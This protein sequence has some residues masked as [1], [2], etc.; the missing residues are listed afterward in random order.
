MP[1]IQTILLIDDSPQDREMYLRYLLKDKRY[2]YKI[3]ETES[4]EEGLQLC[5]E[6]MPDV[7]LL[8]YRLPDFDGLEVLEELKERT[9]K[10]EFP[11]V[12]LTGQGNEAIAV[13]A[14]KNGARDYLVKGQLTGE[15]LRNI[16]HRVIDRSRLMRQLQQSQERLRLMSAIALRIRSCLN[17]Q[18]TLQ[19]TVTEVRHFLQCDRVVVY[20]FADDMSGT[21]VAESLVPGYIA[22]WKSQINDTCFQKGAGYN[23]SQGKRRAIAN[24]YEAGLTKCHIQLLEKF[25]VKANLVVPILIDRDLEISRTPHLWGLLIAHQCSD[26]R[27]WE[28]AELEFLDKLAVQ[29]AIAI[30]QAE[31]YDRAQAEIAQRQQTE[32]ELRQTQNAL[33]LVNQDLE[34]RVRERTKQLRTSTEQLRFHYENSPLAVIEWDSK[35][36][37]KRWSQQAEHIFGWKSSEVFG[38]SFTEFSLIY[39]EDLAGINQI[40]AQLINKEIKNLV[41]QNRNI[42]KFGRVIDCEWYVSAL[43]D[44]QGNL[45]SVLSQAQDITDRLQMEVTLRERERKFY[46]IFDRAV[47]FI[48][49]LEPNGTLIE[50]NQ[51]AL[52]FGGFSLSEVAGKQF[53][54]TSWWTIS[55]EI[56][57]QLKDAVSRAAKGE[58]IRYEVDVIGAEN[59]IATIDFSLKPLINESKNV[60]LLISEG[61]D[62]TKRKQAEAAL[63][64]SEQQLRA[65]LDNSTTVVYLKDIEGRFLR[66]NQEFATIFENPAAEIIGKTDYDLFPA[67]IAD[68]CRANDRAVLDKKQTLRIEEEILHPD[69]S[70]HTYLS[71]KFVLYDDRGEPYGICGLSTD[72]S[73]RKQ[74]EEALRQSE[75]RFRLLVNSAPVG[76]FQ[77]DAHGD[78]IFVNSRWLEFAG[79]SIEEAMGK[80]WARAIHGDDRDRVF[81]EWYKAAASGDKFALECRYK[82]PTGKI[83]WV[84]ASAVPMRDASGAIIG[85]LGTVTDI[86]EQKQ[87]ETEIRDAESAIRALYKVASSPKLSFED[88]LQG[89]LAMGRRHFDLDIGIVARIKGNWY[90]AIAA[91]S[92]SRCL[93]SI[94]PGD[95][96]KFI[97]NINNT[98]SS[99]TESIYLE[100]RSNFNAIDKKISA[101]NPGHFIWKIEENV[102]IPIF[103]KGQKYADLIFLAIDKKT[104]DKP[105]NI[106]ILK[107]M[108]QWVGQEIERLSAKI[109][110]EK[111]M[112]RALLIG[113]ITREIR[114]SL[115]MQQIFQTAVNQMGQAFNVSR[116]AI[117]MYESTPTPKMPC[118][119]E[120]LVSGWPSMRDVNVPVVGNIHAEQVLERERAIASNDVYSDPLLQ[121]VEPICRQFQIKSMLAIRTSYN[122]LPN[123]T[124]G[125]HQCDT[126]R[127]WTEDEIELLE[128]VASQVGIAIVQA[129]LLEQE[130]QYSQTLSDRNSELK[131]AKEQAEVANQAKTRFLANMSHELRTPLNAI[132]GFTQFMLR[133]TSLSS[134]RQ[135]QLKIVN[136]SGEH[137]LSLINDIL[138]MS[139]IEAGQVTLNENSFDLYGLLDSL[140][141]MLT[142]KAKSK[143]L[144]LIF[145]RTPDVPQY[146]KTDESKLR[147]ILINLIGNAIKFTESGSV[148]VRVGLG[149]GELQMADNPEIAIGNEQFAMRDERLIL[150]FEISDTGLGIAPDEIDT[151]FTHFVQST[152]GRNSQEGTGLGLPISQEF[153]QLMGGEIKVS[154]TLNRGT[155]FTFYILI[156]PALAAPIPM[157]RASDRVIKL[158]PD[159]TIY[160]ISIVEDRAENRE[161]LRQLLESVGFEVKTAENGREALEL[162]EDWSPHLIWMD[163]QMPVMGGIEATKQIKSTPKGQSTTVIALTASAFEEDRA[164]ILSAGCDDFVRKPWREE[165]IFEKIAEHLGVRY[166]YEEESKVTSPQSEEV[167]TQLTREALQVMPAEWIEQLY[168]A[169]FR[170]NEKQ[171]MKLIEQIPS[172]EAP[173]ASTL[174]ELI[175]NFHLDTII[176]LTQLGSP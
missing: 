16:V 80:G 81:T 173:L 143:G 33:R 122:N 118:V 145:N 95:T 149:N 62:I 155:T 46:G 163:M 104:R 105:R 148:T 98:T 169:A 119:A 66:I 2:S 14:M 27:Q 114:S 50:A 87:A 73:D 39:S 174:T 93:F 10:S 5:F 58:T 167:P 92:P 12:M 20:Q 127:I 97:K 76:I 156:R 65:I 175:D 107:L 170:A 150:T 22:S 116:C 96:F 29:I 26:F 131:I 17:L 43:F 59:Q 77:T 110:L 54:E 60:V 128:A 72:I 121:A 109:E 21:I 102:S 38:R 135:Q 45:V 7:I 89:L 30:N 142:L 31:L 9:G 100:L 106:E 83:L 152:T 28:T 153:V 52:D 41:Y 32:I 6:A 74:A 162:W 71:I 1:P 63:Y 137:L 55:Q 159:E 147:Q 75:E 176:K 103:F 94:D 108:A 157:K 19:T 126:F 18:E 85:H 101:E 82:N 112:Q 138:S 117:H 168:Q 56:Q 151:L 49:L 53:W 129:K 160:R 61:R 24:I 23:Y 79:L 15:N 84:F 51:T 99:F 34:E 88:R 67:D 4:G 166:I 133:D 146:I 37:V 3:L 57:D 11:V 78:C 115:N 35:F 139:K 132:L 48:S 68:V 91:Q 144:Q 69:G 164:T 90:E 64:K 141:E 171:I 86:T 8:D 140:K 120:Y 44:E 124:I 123:G 161:I 25:Q 47:Q 125:L 36:R 154:S 172:Q 40:L 134:D 136:R 70:I 130:K 111:Q 158:A 42:T 13:Q 113:K 165:I